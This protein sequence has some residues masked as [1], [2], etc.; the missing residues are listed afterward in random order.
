MIS[1]IIPHL[2]QP[3]ALKQCLA[4]LSVQRRPR[5]PVEFIVVD[6]G[7]T[8]MPDDVC[9]AFPEVIVLSELTPGPGPARNLGASRASGDIL[10]FID[11]DCLA[12]GGWLSQIEHC[13]S[14]NAEIAILGGDV[15][16]ACQD[17]RR[18]TLLE[19]YE[20][21]FAYR[22]NEYIA[23]QGFAGTGNL[24]VR[25]DIFAEVGPFGGIEIAEDRDWGA[26]SIVARLPHKILF[27]HDCLSPGSQEPCRA[28]PQMGAAYS[29]RFC[30]NA[31]ET[32]LAAALDRAQRGRRTFA[33]RRGDSDRPL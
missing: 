30:A 12:D 11:A 17:P 1:V 22:M 7:S 4:S 33:G 3:D 5:Q 2:D 8:M 14:E 16:I 28:R 18:P 9:S 13:F 24:A 26:A 32:R 19:A 31:V 27:E 29:T 21:V 20:S 6:N 23:R 25:A 10:A 15:R